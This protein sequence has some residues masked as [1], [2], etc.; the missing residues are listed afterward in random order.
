VKALAVRFAVALFLCLPACALVRVRQMNE[1][2]AAASQ[3][4]KRQFGEGTFVTGSLQNDGVSV[5]V[6]LR[7]DAAR[8][9]AIAPLIKRVIDEHF[10]ERVTAL[11]L[12]RSR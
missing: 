3:E 10:H 8:D 7:S 1:D 2:V 12:V 6:H 9:D 4:L 11:D 5:T